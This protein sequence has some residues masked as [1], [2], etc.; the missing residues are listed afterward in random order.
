MADNDHDLLVGIH[1]D[2]R[3][4][5]KDVADIS[6]RQSA[7]SA[8]LRDVESTAKSAAENMREL[9]YG[10]GNEDDPGLF[11]RVKAIEEKLLRDDE[12]RAMR[13][14]LLRGVTAIG[15]MV[16]SLFGGFVVWLLSHKG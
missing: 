13:G 14:N 7:D 16:A 1:G 11:R 3:R 4:L 6:G 5:V 15:A 2:V 10:N 9:K 8:R 12:R